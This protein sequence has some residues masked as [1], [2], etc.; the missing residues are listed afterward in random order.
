MRKPPALSEVSHKKAFALGVERSEILKIKAENQKK[1]RLRG[2]AHLRAAARL[3]QAKDFSVRLL[4]CLP[5]K[6]PLWL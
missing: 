1:A 3:I 5:V 6:G 2:K 4:R